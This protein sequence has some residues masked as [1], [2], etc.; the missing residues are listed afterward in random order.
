MIL[1]Q[2]QNEGIRWIRSNLMK[3][4]G[5]LLADRMGL[6]K[7]AQAI[8]LIETAVKYGP[9]GIVCPAYLVFN[10]LDEL[11][12][13]G[14]NKK[15]CVIDS[16]K[17][18]I[19][20]DAKLFISSYNLAVSPKIIKQL[21]RLNWMLWIC[22][23]A[24]YL[25]GWDTLRSRKILG[26]RRKTDKYLFARSK[27]FLLMTGTPILNRI[28]ELYN[29]IYRIAPETLNHMSEYEF[30]S[31]YA[32]RIVHTPYGVKHFGVKNVDQLKNRLKEVMLVRTKIEGLLGKVDK[33]IRLRMDEKALQKYIQQETVFLK[34]I[35][36]DINKVE[37]DLTLKKSQ[38]D[39]LWV[40]RQE[41]AKF[42]IPVLLRML[43]DL[44]V[45][46]KP[47]TI[48]VFHR[49]VQTELENAIR[50]KFKKLKIEIINGSVSNKNRHEIIKRFQKK[51]F[52]ILLAT[53]GA[54]KEGVNL[55]AGQVVV[56]L[57][58]AWTPA[59][60]QQAIGRFWRKGQEKTVVVYY[61]YFKAGVD[62]MVI[63]L[64]KNKQRVIKELI[65]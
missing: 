22:D 65:G 57:E 59:I 51:E 36:V 23:E 53:I 3:H 35:G 15:I 5:V 47:L 62:K 64:L 14:F 27:K 8:D 28:G 49:K 46:S 41:I 13:W 37:Q 61:L 9:V 25:K 6:G 44:L 50:K 48:Y 4:K 52:D 19:E 10:W 20:Y 26:T 55:T 56:F 18:V 12:L 60:I 54:L 34:S 1:T 32:G 40:I 21:L 16:G 2:A 24:H 38:I 58:L 43:P 7:T 39:E 31:R 33:H 17:Q 42:K 30:L 11:E 45:Q 29:L 63:N